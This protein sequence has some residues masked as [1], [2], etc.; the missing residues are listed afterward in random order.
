MVGQCDETGK[1]NVPCDEVTRSEQAATNHAAK[2]C[3]IDCA[4]AIPQT[5]QKCSHCGSYQ[6]RFLNIIA[7][8]SPAVS[9]V[10]VL[11][12]VAQVLFAFAQ[13]LE[14][15]RDRVSAAT[16]LDLAERAKLAILVHEKAITNLTAELSAI[17]AVAELSATI[18][19]AEN[20][21]RRAC[22]K[23][24]SRIND[25]SDPLMQTAAN[26]YNRILAMYAKGILPSA[27]SKVWPQNVD[28]TRL[29][30]AHFRKEYHAAS[31]IFRADIVQR[32]FQLTSTRRHDKMAFFAEIL[33][34]DVSLD[35]TYYAGRFFVELANDPGLQWSAFTLAPL[36]EWW[37]LHE[38]QITD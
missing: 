22:E 10:M 28:P 30:L 2:R 7:A 9:L 29:P 15:R 16:A 5:A 21:D 24:L 33:K 27:N 14:A 20:D 13:L 11:T 23:L 4:Q 38:D 17:S 12:A 37:K 25:K 8:A 3:C 19:R 31:P 1:T 36:L 32:V 35:A 26:A 18:L 6:R 34:D